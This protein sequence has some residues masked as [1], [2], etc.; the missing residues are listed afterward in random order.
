MRHDQIENVAVNDQITTAID[1][2]VNGIFYDFNAAEMRAVITSQKFVMVAGDIDDTGT[3][4]G[5]P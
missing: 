5:L 2:C 4:A 1:A 3:L